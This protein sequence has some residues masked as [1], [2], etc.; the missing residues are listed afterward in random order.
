MWGCV[1][2]SNLVAIAFAVA[3][4]A[5]AFEPAVAAERSH[6][7]QVRAQV[8]LGQVQ[9]QRTRGHAPQNRARAKSR[10][11]SLSARSPGCTAPTI[12]LELKSSVALVLDQETNE[13][14]FSKNPKAVLPIA[15]ITKLMTAL[16]VTEAGLPLDEMVTV[17]QDDVDTEKGSHSRLRVGT[18]L[19]AGRCCTWR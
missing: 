2:L 11:G 9:P 6:R 8:R 19:T 1:K 10:H 4:S 16:V 15:S 14:L 5:V 17:T 18:Q 13:V 12:P 7:Y 3:V